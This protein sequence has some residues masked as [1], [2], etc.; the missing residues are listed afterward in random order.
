MILLKEKETLNVEH[1]FYEEKYRRGDFKYNTY[2]N[3][4]IIQ[5][6]LSKY[7]IK[8]NA[9]VLDVGCGVGQYSYSFAESGLN[10]VGVDFSKTGIK[11]AND[12]YGDKVMWIVGDGLR[13]PLK[14]K[15][16]VIFCSGFSPFNSAEGLHKTNIIGKYLFQF[17]K[18]DGY[19]IFQWA[20]DLSNTLSTG[21]WMNYNLMAIKKYFSDLNCGE[22]VGLFAT[23]RQLFPI[24]GKYALSNLV[25]RMCIVA[26]RIH[27]RNIRIICIIKKR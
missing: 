10:I 2:T 6:L 8:K 24:C 14:E 19:F 4:K 22:I 20:S 15:F 13:L 17:L 9:F 18:S 25:T 7:L 21:N 5:S 1:K 23:N 27:K 16:D 3:L 11:K 12:R 26:Q